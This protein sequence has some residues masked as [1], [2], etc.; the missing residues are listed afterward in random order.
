MD[1]NL[2]YITSVENIPYEGY[3]F[4]VDDRKIALFKIAD[5]IYAIEDRCTHLHVQLTMGFREKNII[6]CPLHG[7]L[8]DIATGK[9]L[10]GPA[11]H[12][13]ETF[14]VVVENGEVYFDRGQ[15]T[16]HKRTKDSD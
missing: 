7:A 5:K 10:Q 16:K 3:S 13:L 1:Q 6:G 9:V 11:V 8:F 4:N 15:I 14:R 2:L 12:D